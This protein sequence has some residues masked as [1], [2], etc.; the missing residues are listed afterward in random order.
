MYLVSL[1]CRHLTLPWMAACA[2]AAL[3]LKRSRSWK[4]CAVA[5]RSMPSRSSKIPHLISLVCN[6]PCYRFGVLKCSTLADQALH[7]D[8][9]AS[10]I[11]QAA[12]LPLDDS[13]VL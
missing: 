2:P 11:E 3:S 9:H 1:P 10:A 5:Q 6:E 7:V 4:T 12:T 13:A 8:K